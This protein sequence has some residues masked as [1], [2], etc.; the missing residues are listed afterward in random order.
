MMSANA[1]GYV[2]VSWY[3]RYEKWRA[4]YG[5]NQ[6][7]KHI[8]YFKMNGKAA[9]AYDRAILEVD[10]EHCVLNFSI[11]QAQR[12]VYISDHQLKNNLAKNQAIID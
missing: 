8:G 10:P 9:R 7:H 4:V 2:G 6:T 11:P 3:K 5:I 1:S 12:D